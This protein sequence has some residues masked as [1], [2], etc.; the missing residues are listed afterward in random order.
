MVR[1]NYQVVGNL[2]ANIHISRNVRGITHRKSW[3]SLTSVSEYIINEW[4]D[5]EHIVHLI[6]SLHIHMY[7]CTYIICIYIIYVI[8]MVYIVD[9]IH[10]IQWQKDISINGNPSHLGP[11]LVHPPTGIPGMSASECPGWVQNGNS[12]LIV[13]LINNEHEG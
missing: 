11:S 12:P 9:I 3:E 6:Q 4:I 8:Y 1:Y 2:L 5:K 13:I 7:I 10:T